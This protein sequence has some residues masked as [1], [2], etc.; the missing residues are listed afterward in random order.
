MQEN[1]YRGCG[2]WLAITFFMSFEVIAGWLILNLTIAAVIDGLAEA[3]ADDDRLFRTADIEGFLERW[4]EYDH[5]ATGSIR[6]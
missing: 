6:I 1:G 3:Q 2:S 4:Q 5:Y